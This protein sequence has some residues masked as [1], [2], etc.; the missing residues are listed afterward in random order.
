MLEKNKKQRQGTQVAQH[1]EH[2]DRATVT[3][4]EVLTRAGPKSRLNSLTENYWQ[5]FIYRMKE[6]KM[7]ANKSEQEPMEM[8]TA[9]GKAVRWGHDWNRRCAATEGKAITCR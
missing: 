8:G 2:Q 3:W 7:K 1:T 4:T 9:T 6:I 5:D